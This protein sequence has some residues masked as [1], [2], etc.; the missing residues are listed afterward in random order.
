MWP[1]LLSSSGNGPREGL[2]NS[3]P[4]E[5]PKP[6]LHSSMQGLLVTPVQDKWPPAFSSKRTLQ[7]KSGNSS[8]EIFIVYELD[9]RNALERCSKVMLDIQL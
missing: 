7:V 4:E 9:K 6:Q 1:F 5:R 3:Q 8:L 2:P